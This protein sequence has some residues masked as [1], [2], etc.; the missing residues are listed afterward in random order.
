[1]EMKHYMPCKWGIASTEPPCPGPA[2]LL[3]GYHWINNGA[4]ALFEFSEGNCRREKEADTDASLGDVLIFLLRAWK[5]KVILLW[6]KLHHAT[7][8]WALYLLFL[9]KSLEKVHGEGKKN[10]QEFVMKQ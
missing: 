5:G 2:L 1:M 7:S 8:Q 6:L 10:Q 4:A 3:W 9:C